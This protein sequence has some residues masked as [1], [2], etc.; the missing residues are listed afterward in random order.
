MPKEVSERLSEQYQEIAETI[1]IE[2]LG[3]ALTDYIEPNTEDEELNKAIRKAQEGIAEFE[4]IIAPYR[5]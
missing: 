5:I 1:E 4:R 3:Y 2:G